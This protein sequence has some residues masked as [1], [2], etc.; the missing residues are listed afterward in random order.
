MNVNDLNSSAPF[1]CEICDSVEHVTLN[2]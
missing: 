2:C 1:P